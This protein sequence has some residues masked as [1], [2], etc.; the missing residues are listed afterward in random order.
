MK[1]GQKTSDTDIRSGAESVP[2]SSLN[3][4]VIYYFLLVTTINKKNIS[5]L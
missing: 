5:R 2:V 4:G 3:K 1:K